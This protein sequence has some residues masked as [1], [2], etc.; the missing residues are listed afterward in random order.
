MS[1]I[2]KDETIPSHKILVCSRSEV[3]KTMFKGNFFESIDLH[4]SID[5]SEFPKDHF[6]PFLE[7]L[8]ADSSNIHTLFSP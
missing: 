2:L 8:Y 5:V 4:P 1:F 3:I 7:Y 6:L